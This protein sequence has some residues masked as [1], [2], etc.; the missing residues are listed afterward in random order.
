MIK[1]I[2]N[3]QLT[4]S[5]FIA[6]GAFLL[7]SKP[8]AAAPAMTNST[9]PVATQV[10]VATD[11]TGVPETSGWL[12]TEEG[13]FY[14]ENGLLCT[15]VISVEGVT[16]LLDENGVQQTGWQTIH[17]IR[18]YFFPDTK[19]AAIGV[20]NIDGKD[21]LFD[22]TGAQKTGWRTVNDI[23]Y[24][25]DPET[26]EAVSGW[27]SYAD[28]RYFTD[29]QYEKQTGEVTISGTRYLL[30]NEYG[31]QHT[32][33]C[34][35]SDQTISYYNADGENLKGWQDIEKNKYYFDSN[36]IMQTGW[37]TMSG[38]KY[39]FTSSGVLQTGWQNIDNERYYFDSAGVMQTGFQK[40]GTLTYYLDN[41][42]KMA[43]EW[44]TINNKK[45]YFNKK[46]VM[47]TGLIAIGSNQ[48]YFNSNGIM[49]TGWQSLGNNKY[50]FNN[51]GIMQ[52][53]WLTLNSNQYHFN[54]SGIMQTGWQTISG[55]LYYFQNDG[56]MLKSTR[57]DDY[58]ID[59]NGVATKFQYPKA[60]AKLDVVGWNLNKAFQWA[61]SMT[62][63]GHNAS[64]PDTAAPG[65]KWYA[66]YGFDNNKGNCYVM[67]ATFCE[68]AR[69]LGYDAKQI[70]GQVPL[71]K[72]GLGP[73][74]W[75]EITING[76]VYVYDPDF[77]NETGRNGFQIQYG[78]S[79]TWRYVRG[80]VMSD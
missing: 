28:R 61:A 79:G 72:G 53:G 44:Q 50:Y 4:L 10:S 2:R 31:Y 57:K 6:A 41:N 56:T 22:F 3:A 24:Y 45:Y 27:I 7:L 55:K 33:F 13:K 8:A 51:D 20:Q 5:V 76:S 80:S 9:I 40:M 32:G 64:M 17:G 74:S 67:A 25:Y 58:K 19:E 66:D 26:G 77:T 15:G 21:Y 78:Q 37:I 59:A 75:V 11:V 18:H 62:Y 12:E 71:R 52:T 48:Y 63:Y 42:G 68:M 46:G 43:T 73:H 70:S 49:Q 60:V 14:Y 23:R 35:F 39:H 38:N 47:Q 65:T 34:H 54:S 36:G 1:S 30:D 29:T 16:Y 69:E